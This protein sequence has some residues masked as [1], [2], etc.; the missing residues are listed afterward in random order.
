[1]KITVHTL[2]M[3]T[4]KE[5]LASKASCEQR[6]GCAGRV[7]P[8]LAIRMVPKKTFEAGTKHAPAD[9]DVLPLE[10]IMLQLMFAKKSE[11]KTSKDVLQFFRDN[12]MSEPP[13]A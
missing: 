4:L 9:F 11:L 5:I 6:K 3:T 1:M 7:Q 2:R 12:A 13:R 8:G 10:N